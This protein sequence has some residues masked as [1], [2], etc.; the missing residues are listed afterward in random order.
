M[1]SA[2]FKVGAGL[3]DEGHAR[4]IVAL[5]GTVKLTLMHSLN[6]QTPSFDDLP[7]RIFLDSSTLQALQD[8]GESVDPAAPESADCFRVR[9][10]SGG[11]SDLPADLSINSRRL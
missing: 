11:T 4:I 2:S 10:H 3:E 8:Y 9:R 1:D 7:R 5:P 6:D